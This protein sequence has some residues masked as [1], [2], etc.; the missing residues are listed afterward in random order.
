MYSD[1]L[2]VD[3]NLIMSDD[4]VAKMKQ[5]RAQAQQQQAQ[6]EQLNQGADT[7]QKLGQVK[8]QNGRSNAAND[9]LGV[10]GNR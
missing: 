2:G 6:A 9:V 3:P 10:L 1:L 4:N 5:E 7:A 8:T